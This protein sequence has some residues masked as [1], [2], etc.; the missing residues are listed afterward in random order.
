MGKM[1]YNRTALSY[2]GTKLTGAG[3]G[4]ASAFLW[5]LWVEGWDWVEPFQSLSFHRT[6]ELGLGRMLWIALYGFG[7]PVSMLLDGLF[8]WRKTKASPWVLVL[9]HAAAGFL[10]FLPMVLRN[11][12]EAFI[13]FFIAG[14]IGALCASL[15]YIGT[16]WGRQSRQVRW[17]LGCA[18]P[19]VILFVSM[20]LPQAV[21]RGWSEQVGDSSFEASFQYM[22]GVYPVPIQ[23]QE[24]DVIQ[25]DI[26]WRFDEGG[27]GVT[28]LRVW[29]PEGQGS[30]VDWETDQSGSHAYSGRIR[31]DRDGPY[32]LGIHGDQVRGRFQVTWRKL[33]M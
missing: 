27:G 12:P 30:R 11:L 10:F 16:L 6:E 19:L 25:F 5:A 21:T 31:A 14:S 33:E 8:R 2:V 23:A 26:T 17:I 4:I 13:Y 22:N 15:F 7:L 9:L 29:G 20:I 3:F 1:V 18:V 28:G 32:Y 24:G